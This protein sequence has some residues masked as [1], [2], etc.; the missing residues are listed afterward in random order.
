LALLRSSFLTDLGSPT[1]QRVS[2]GPWFR[3]DSH[4]L[5]RRATFETAS[6]QIFAQPH[7]F[8]WTN[9][10]LTEPKMRISSRHR[11]SQCASRPSVKGNKRIE[12]ATVCASHMCTTRTPILSPSM[13]QWT[14]SQQLAA[15]PPSES[16]EHGARVR[17]SHTQM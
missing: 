10:F 5:T 1:R 6:I 7:A 3:G 4:S 13:L 17:T 2:E 14:M 11:R 15:T 9:Q 8:R 16:I 12:L